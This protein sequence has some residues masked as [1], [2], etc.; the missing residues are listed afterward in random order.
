MSCDFKTGLHPKF[1]TRCV[2]LK[3]VW[4][5]VYDVAGRKSYLY[6][7]LS[8]YISENR[9]KIN[10]EN[11]KKISGNIN[12]INLNYDGFKKNN[13]YVCFV[14]LCYC[15]VLC[16]EEYDKYNM[17]KYECCLPVFALF[18]FVLTLLKH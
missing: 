16:S 5:N 4:Y 14:L 17:L 7:V 10:C 13:K 3:H 8:L 1:K 15:V 9:A 2:L 6:P 12:K 18:S 11:E